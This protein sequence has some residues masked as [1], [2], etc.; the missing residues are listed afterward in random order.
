MTRLL[1]SVLDCRLQVAL[2]DES[3]APALPTVRRGQ[4]RHEVGITRDD[5]AASRL[6]CGA[7][8]GSEVPRSHFSEARLAVREED[9]ESTGRL[10]GEVSGL[11]VC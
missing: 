4:D 7:S 5:H 10:A 11:L 2:G 3:L 6:L 1:F 9:I 8:E